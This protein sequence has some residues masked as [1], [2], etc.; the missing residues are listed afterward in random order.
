MK[1]QAIIFDKDGTLLDFDK[2]WVP[3][4]KTA[5]NEI[6]KKYGGDASLATPM[7]ESIGVFGGVSD[8]KG[9]LCAG[10]Y[11]SIGDAFYDVL[12]KNGADVKKDGFSEFVTEAFHTGTATGEIAPICEN[13]KETLEK[14]KENGIKIAIVTTD[15][16]YTTA[17]CLEKLGIKHCFDAVYT[18]DGKIATKPNPDAL[19]DFCEKIGIEK[20]NLIMVGDTLTDM[21]FAQNGGVRAVGVAKTQGNKDVLMTM[22]DTVIYD[23]S[24]IFEVID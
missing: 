23:V 12:E 17:Q 2:F 18:D 11:K 22:T 14:L 3:V 15:D 1:T 21:R 24:H 10:T 6:L 19:Y 8:I 16:F 20:E 7:L 4:T 9:E 13:L 5:I